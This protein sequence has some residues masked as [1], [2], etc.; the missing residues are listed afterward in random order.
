MIGIYR[1]QRLT[2]EH[3]EN[4]DNDDLS[5]PGRQGLRNVC[6][7]KQLVFLWLGILLVFEEFFLNSPY[8]FSV[9]RV[10]FLNLV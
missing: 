2:E 4:K 7:D 10:V 9:L 3:D 1:K 6:L 5:G 8:F